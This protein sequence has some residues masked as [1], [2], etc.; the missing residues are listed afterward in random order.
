MLKILKFKIDNYKSVKKSKG[1]YPVEEF[2]VILERERARVDRNNHPFSVVA[3]EILDSLGDT[4]QTYLL[5]HVISKRARSSDS[6]GWLNNH[7]VGVFL[8]DTSTGGACKFANDIFQID[9]AINVFVKY[10]VFKYPSD[11]FTGMER[12]KNYPKIRGITSI[13]DTTNF[14]SV[15]SNA[16]YNTVFPSFVDTGKFINTKDD[17]SVENV[18]EK[19]FVKGIPIW[20]STIDVLGSLLGLVILSPL[21]LIIASFIKIVSPGPIFFKQDRIG[22][23]G[24][25]F[26]FWKFRTMKVD[27]EYNIHHKHIHDLVKDDRP[28][29][30]LDMENDERIIPFGK[31]LRQSCL[32][33]LPQLINVLHGEMSLVG[34]RPCL[35]YEAQEYN[36]WHTKRFDIKP[37]MTGYWQV[38][39][40][41]KTTFKEMIRLDIIYA[42]QMSFWLDCKI[43]LKTVPTIIRQTINELQKRKEN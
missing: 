14:W 25:P 19:N 18:L 11:R 36:L 38:S 17:N 16:V 42:M 5:I 30:K 34:P 9:P 35:A 12:E 33:E 43:L 37:G 39:G 40:K 29:E 4:K 15:S 20:K 6:I 2:W 28:M 8:P 23:K 3:F 13:E 31:F 1:I 27:S 7:Q 22:Y 41:N 10:L 26:N 32:D 24:K 21:F